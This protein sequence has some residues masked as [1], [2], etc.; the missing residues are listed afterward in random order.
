MTVFIQLGVTLAFGALV[1]WLCELWIGLFSDRVFACLLGFG[2]L[3][4]Y[5]FIY[6]RRQARLRQSSTETIE[7]ER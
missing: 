6:D 2:L 3:C 4:L 7:R 1:A 5:A